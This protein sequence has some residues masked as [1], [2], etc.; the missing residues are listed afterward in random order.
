MNISIKNFKKFFAI[1][2]AFLLS[3]QICYAFSD[4][5]RIEFRTDWNG[6][7]IQYDSLPL[8]AR[9]TLQLILKGGPFR[10]RRDGVVFHNRERILPNNPRGF[11]REYTVPTPGVSSRGARRI[12]VG[13][14]NLIF[15]YTGDHYRSFAKIVR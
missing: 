2:V 11:Y 4:A 3:L 12:I 9:Q 8:E 6:A 7:E 13:G 14:K 5:K 15:Y 1:L 10:Y